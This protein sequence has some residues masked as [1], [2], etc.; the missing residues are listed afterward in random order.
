MKGYKGFDK[1]LKCQEKQYEI[2]KT[3]IED[4]ADLCNSGM[5]FCEYPLDCFAYYPPSDSRYCEVDADEVS[6]QRDNDSKRSAKKLT[7]GAEI[8]LSGIINAS[9]KFILEKARTENRVSENT[10]DWSAAT[11]TGDWSA[12]TSTGDQ[13]AATNTGYQSAATNTGYRSAATSTGYQSAATNTGYQSAATST[14]D[15]SAATNT[16]YRSAA[17]NTGYQSAATN[18]GD[19]SAATNTGYQSA[20]TN[21]GYRSA[22]TSTGYQSAATVSGKNSVAVS[23][24]RYGKARGE[25]G[26]AIVLC[27]YD[28]DGTLLRI[29]SEIV[30]GEKIKANTFYTLKN[31]RLVKAERS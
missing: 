8:G 6:D 16:G 2:G 22:A 28:D 19:Q 9:V 26:C 30:D 21:T 20:A 23:T 5:R 15:Q 14:G 29:R 7:I 4:S 17:T 1:N 18:T 25:I 3:E 12:A 13:S 11:N 24:G 27:E 31:G 10:G